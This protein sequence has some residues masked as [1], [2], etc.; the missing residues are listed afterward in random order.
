MYSGSLGGRSGSDTLLGMGVFSS[1]VM[2]FFTSHLHVYT[3]VSNLFPLT[4]RLR[5]YLVPN[6]SGP[7]YSSNRPDYKCLDED[8]DTSSPWECIENKLPKH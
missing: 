1:S 5:A 7:K 6:V 2:A 3:I 4:G 8:M